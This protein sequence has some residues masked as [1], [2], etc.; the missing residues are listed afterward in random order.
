MREEVTFGKFSIPKRVAD[1]ICILIGAVVLCSHAIYNGFPLVYPDTGTYISACF[2]HFLPRDRSLVYS[3]FI[4]HISLATSLWIPVFVQS[5]FVSWLV[6]LLFR[7]VAHRRA[8][9]VIHFFTLVL[10]SLT[11]GIAVNCGQLI[12]DVFTPIVLLTS[13]LLLF[14]S[15]L[16]R[17]TKIALAVLFI[18]SVTTHLSNLPVALG[19][20]AWVL[21]S[22]FIF[23]K[24]SGSAFNFFRSLKF[25]VLLP[26]AIL[27]V[28]ILNFSVAGK[29]QFRA[30]AQHVFMMNR[31]I[32]CGIIDDY[33]DENCG[34]RFISLCNYKT[35]L[36]QMDFLW[37]DK[38]AVNDYYGWKEDGWNKAKPEYDSIISD[39]FSNGKYVKQFIYH[40][41][42]DGCRQLVSFQTGTTP[43]MTA[44][45][46]I[47]TSI[48]W[49]F[50][51]SL[52]SYTSSRQNT[53]G[54]N[55]SM[56]NFIQ[57]IFIKVSGF[58]FLLILL[59]PR[60]S[61][62]LTPRM[63]AFSWLVIFGMIFNAFT[64][65]TFAMLDDRYQARLIWLVPLLLIVF[66]ANDNFLRSLRSVFDKRLRTDQ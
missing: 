19:I 34:K 26:L 29:W 44:H 43:K 54:L 31:L 66:F 52:K 4:R 48:H 42:K 32:Q 9:Y 49:H 62:L 55:Y 47:Y 7:H 2:E 30:D 21:I 18:F 64:V 11:T 37:D 56:F 60:F 33:L 61:K 10:L 41:W 35:T 27:F 50:P 28:C 8:P 3:F 38:S 24:R 1:L 25:L 15:E 46:A 23:R 40:S 45:D 13:G 20:V 17:G 59:I 6:F 5:A 22:S 16:S 14:V 65:V 36:H 53:T 63:R 51:K 57:N 58:L 12:A 39:V